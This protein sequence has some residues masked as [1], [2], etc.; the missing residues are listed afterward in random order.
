MYRR[1]ALSGLCLFL[2]IGAAARAEEP[3]AEPPAT[4]TIPVKTDAEPRRHDEPRDDE[5]VTYSGI[6]L[7]RV[8]T[9]YD[10]LKEAVN[11]DF[12]L[13]IRVPNLNWIAAE[14]NGSV[15]IIPGENK[16]GSSVIG[17]SDGNCQINNPPFP[18]GCT[19]ASGGQQVT[20]SGSD[21]Q[22]QLL[23]AYLVLKSPGRFY[24]TGRA[25][26]GYQVTSIDEIT[27]K[28]RSGAVYSGGLGWRY[29]KD[30]GG[31]ELVYARMLSGV[32]AIGFTVTYGFGPKR[33]YRDR[34]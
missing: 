13:G 12:T 9:H 2:G 4:Q 29:G 27:N 24:A 23:G 18:P 32:D 3:E 19:P 16:G 21:F 30:L 17:G 7:S 20:S 6:G 1:L 34:D 15:T 10:N 8:K 28:E 26:Y 25:G 22:M 33:S 5:S 31:V 14:V 11:L